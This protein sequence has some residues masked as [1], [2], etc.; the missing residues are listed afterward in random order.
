[1]PKFIPF[2]NLVKL[3]QEKLG[4]D[5]TDEI[6][7]AYQAD[8]NALREGIATKSDD[9]RLSLIVTTLNEL[10]QA[11]ADLKTAQD[12]LKPVSIEALK[13]SVD[14]LTVKPPEG[15]NEFVTSTTTSLSAVQTAL[16]S[17]L[18]KLSQLPTQEKSEPVWQGIKSDKAT[19]D[20]MAALSSTNKKA[21]EA[22]QSLFPH[23]SINWDAQ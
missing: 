9:S 21:G 12:A 7:K 17:V 5:V 11:V 15:Y 14:T 23:S 22:T 19:Q 20:L 4:V 16:T 10:K 3:L 13:S 8:I 18:E 2:Q 1:M 6:E